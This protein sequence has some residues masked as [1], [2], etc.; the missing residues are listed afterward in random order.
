MKVDQ[1]KIC[2]P[3]IDISTIFD[4]IDI[5]LYGSPREKYVSLDLPHFLKM[6]K[7]HKVALIGLKI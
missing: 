5:F 7:E 2:R 3:T 4:D 1:H 6:P